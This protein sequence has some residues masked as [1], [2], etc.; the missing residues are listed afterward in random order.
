MKPRKSSRETDSANPGRL[1]RLV[2]PTLRQQIKAVKQVAQCFRRSY[3]HLIGEYKGDIPPCAERNQTL[4]LEEAVKTLSRLND[5]AHPTAADCDG[6][7][8]KKD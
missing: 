1:Q 2:K 8:Q 3:T 7:A 6:G 5:Q 4:A